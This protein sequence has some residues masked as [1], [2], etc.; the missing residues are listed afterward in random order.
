[1]TP[2]RPKSLVPAGMGDTGLIRSPDVDSSQPGSLRR[3]RCVSVCQWTMR[4]IKN[5]LQAHLGHPVP[6]RKTPV[7]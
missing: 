2:K 4:R 1:V 3:N 5:D 6:P 7:S